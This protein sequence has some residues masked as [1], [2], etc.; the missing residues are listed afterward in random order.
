[1]KNSIIINISED[2]DYSSTPYDD[3]YRTLLNDCPGLIIPVVNEVF[4]KNHKAE[5]EITILNNE[6][7][8]NGQKGQ[9]FERIT[10][11]IFRIEGVC[12]HIECQSTIDGSILVR[13]FEYDSQIA[14]HD[15]TVEDETL[16]VKFPNTALMYLRHNRN[17]P[18]CMTINIKVPGDECSYRVPVL[19]VQQYTIE[20]IFSKKLFFLIPFY[21]FIYE[22]NFDKYNSSDER[23]KELTNVYE[24]IVAQLELEVREGVLTE[25]IKQM[26]L[27]M[28]KKV[29][30][31]ISR[32]YSNVKERISEIMGGQI[33]DYEAKTILLRGKE[34]MLVEQ[35]SKKLK[36]G[37][38]KDQIAEALEVDP[39]MVEKLIKEYNLIP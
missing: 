38:T 17:T 19:K 25:Y 8:I 22:K 32:K 11:S 12:Y 35:I 5:D 24:R 20:D 28:A 2:I 31:H 16:C 36:K 15:S 27:E 21:I 34:S 29:L 1:M 33:L 3:V 14:L 13:I 26:I 23:M 39:E 7:F 4:G 30:E 18:D 6:L 37:K 9:Q 10:D